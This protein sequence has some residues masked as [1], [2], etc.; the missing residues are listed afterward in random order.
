MKNSLKSQLSKL[1]YFQNKRCNHFFDSWKDRISKLDED[2]TYKKQ[3]IVFYNSDKL[4][5]ISM[6]TRSVEIKLRYDSVIQNWIDVGL[7]YSNI[8][9]PIN[10][11]SP[12]YS[13]VINNSLNDLKGMNYPFQGNKIKQSNYELLC[14][15]DKY[16][17]KIIL[18]FNEKM[19]LCPAEYKDNFLRCR[20][21]FADMKDKPAESIRAALQ[22]L[23]LWSDLFWQTGHNLM[24]FGRLDYLFDKIPSNESDEEIIFLFKEFYKAMHRYYPFKSSLEA[25]GDTGQI[26]VLGGKCEDDSYFYNRYTHL[27]IKALKDNPIPDPKLLLRVSEVMPESVLR[28]AVELISTG[29]GSPLLANDDVVIPALIEF[30]YSKSDAYNYITS[31][32][33]EP[34]AY[35][36]SSEVNN[37]RSI[38]YAEALVN[39]YMDDVFLK[40]D[41]YKDIVELYKT[42]LL[43]YLD[44]I[45]ESMDN[46]VWE[47]EPLLTLFTPNCIHTNKSISKGGAK[48]NSFGLLGDGVGNTVN[49]LLLI[50]YHVFGD[51]KYSLSELKEMCCSDFE[52]NSELAKQLT[53]DSNYYGKDLEDVIETTEFLKNIVAIKLKDYT[54]KYGGGVKWGI[55]SSNYMRNGRETKATM[56]G[57]KTGQNLNVHISGNIVPYTE[58]FRFASRI[59]Y[60]GQFSNGNVVDY[61]VSPGLINGNLDKFVTFIKST[62]SLGFFEQQMNV[63]S[64]KTLIEAKKNPNMHPNLIVRVWGFSAYFND[65]TDEYKNVLIERALKNEE[66][67]SV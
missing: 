14:V 33:W 16:I 6:L 30:G 2:E 25:M 64:S 38:N 10:N 52:H 21:I 43:D 36:N 3:K 1:K 48:Y 49:S 42:K 32:C 4:K 63:V 23:A 46:I 66:A 15:V 60:N 27:F 20:N 41:S 7:Y 55:S 37:I 50:K 28:E 54:N 26:I 56:D 40:C 57:R 18:S 24:G 29:V 22:R 62:I 58:L 51:K 12:N 8:N 61:F 31:A 47:D 35:G 44:T 59:N 19:G 65:L 53:D 67:C 13:L 5:Q 45:I 11:T 17:D 9:L 39:M 34:I